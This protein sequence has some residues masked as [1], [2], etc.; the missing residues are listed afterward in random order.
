MIYQCKVLET[1]LSFFELC[2]TVET[3]STY[4]ITTLLTKRINAVKSSVYQ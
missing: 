2:L 1:V 3:V 4:K